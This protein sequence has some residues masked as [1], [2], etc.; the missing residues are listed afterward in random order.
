LAGASAFCATQLSNPTCLFNSCSGTLVSSTNL[1]GG[2]AG[3]AGGAG[4]S[5]GAGGGGSGGWSYAIVAGGDGGTV[6][7]DGGVLA[8]G[9]AGSGGVVGGANGQAGDR[10]P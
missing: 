6:S 2:S 9:D 4:G 7:V 5:G 10:W 1:A 3:G 8:H